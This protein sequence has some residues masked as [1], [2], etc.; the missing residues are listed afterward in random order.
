[1]SQL[2]S[3]DSVLEQTNFHA[4]PYL[5]L[6]EEAQV[7]YPLEWTVRMAF[8]IIISRYQENHNSHY[9]STL[10]FILIVTNKLQH[11]I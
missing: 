5:Q 1:M 11:L 7:C 6:Y 4:G 10:I 8:I 2:Y 3:V 9:Q